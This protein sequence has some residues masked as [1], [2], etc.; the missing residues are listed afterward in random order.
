M[1]YCFAF[2]A[3]LQFTHA[4]SQLTTGLSRQTVSACAQKPHVSGPLYLQGLAEGGVQLPCTTYSLKDNG[5]SRKKEG[6]KKWRQEGWKGEYG[7][8][9]R[10]QSTNTD[11]KKKGRERS[12]QSCLSDELSRKQAFEEKEVDLER[13]MKWTESGWGCVLHGL[14]IVRT[15]VGGTEIK[16]EVSDW[17]PRTQ[18][19]SKETLEMDTAKR[20]Q[21]WG[22]DGGLTTTFLIW[23]SATLKHPHLLS[24]SIFVSKYPCFCMHVCACVSVCIGNSTNITPSLGPIFL[25]CSF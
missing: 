23:E 2:R 16:G 12:A 5:I 3:S 22:K 25:L 17:V 20:E 4:C 19:Q 11:K 13:T 6:K 21:K 24:I 1:S 9:G 18:M 14:C 8:G 7:R 15:Q 10:Y